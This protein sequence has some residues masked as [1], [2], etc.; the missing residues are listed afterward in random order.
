MKITMLRS[1]L[2]AAL[3]LSTPAAYAG[4]LDDI[5]RAIT[6]PITAPIQA[7][8]DV[9]RGAPPGTIIQNQINTQVAPP[10]HVFQSAAD[11]VQ[12]GHNIVMNIPRGAIQQT[13]GNDWLRGYD[14]L[15]ASQRVQFELAMT[16]GRFL[17][18]CVQTMNCNINQL[19]AMPVA[20]AMRDAYR[21]YITYSYPLP[22]QLMQVLSRVVPPHVLQGA[23][24]AVGRTPDMTVP[25]FL[26]SGHRAFGQDHAVTLG[27]LMIFSR[28]PDLDDEGD[29]I[30]LLHELF[31]VEQYWRYSN[32]A[33][34]AIDGFAVD[35]V[36]NYSAMEQEAQNNAVQRYQ[37]L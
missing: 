23:R 19:A 14:T 22:P 16:S 18:N 37:A 4:P 29:C 33:L 36:R 27:N 31:H 20:A 2:T 5:G 32:N 12:R 6:A 8:R 28:M 26:N 7:T 34:E 21:V 35:Y 17:G 25:G 24:W 15:T 13:L 3:F 1:A 30:W 11:V 9:L 10:A